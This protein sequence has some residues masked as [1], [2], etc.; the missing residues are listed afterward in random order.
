MSVSTESKIE[1]PR[2][3]LAAYLD[4]EL[5]PREEFELDVHLA[6]LFLMFL[7]GIGGEIKTVATV[8][9][10]FGEQFLAVAGFAAHLIY[11]VG[12]GAAILLRTVGGQFIYNSN[13][14]A[15]FLIF[16]FIASAL[17]LSRFLAR[18]NQS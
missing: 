8:F 1:C 11:N 2:S 16:I 13:G 10:Q 5:S 12:V 17:A 3:E 6:A 15:A 4:G 9:L 7:I 18:P 14:S